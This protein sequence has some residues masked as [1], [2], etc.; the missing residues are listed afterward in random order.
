MPRG[1]I[2]R[3]LWIV[4]ADLRA[5]PET[6]YVFGDNM[7]RLGHGGQAAEMR[8]EPNAIGVP[9]KHYPGRAA[10]DY[11]TNA[12][13]A[14]GSPVERQ[15]GEALDLIYQALRDGHDVVIPADGL[16]TGLAQLTTR[17]PL[18]A[19]HIARTLAELERGNP[20]GEV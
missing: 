18:I 5:N 13:W 1:S 20:E 17:A 11:F 12:D 15:V 19:K 6:Y 14:P 7:A 8:G 2:R 10:Q 3:Q 4:R 16:G 9:T